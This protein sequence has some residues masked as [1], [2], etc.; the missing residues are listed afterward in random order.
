MTGLVTF[1]AVILIML[2]FCVLLLYVLFVLLVDL[3]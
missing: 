3:S 1:W 2:L